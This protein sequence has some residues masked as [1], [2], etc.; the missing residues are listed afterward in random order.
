MLTKELKKKRETL[1]KEKS[2]IDKR[3][4]EICR[5]LTLLHNECNHITDDGKDAFIY[6]STNSH[7]DFYKCTICGCVK[8]R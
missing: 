3:I 7:D 8:K 5:E 4:N 1:E 6:K 2:L